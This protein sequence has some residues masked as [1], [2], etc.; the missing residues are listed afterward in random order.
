VKPGDTW[1]R[2]KS[3]HRPAALPISS[4][5]SRRAVSSGGSPA[6][7][8]FAGRKLEHVRHADRLAGLAD[9]EEALA[10]VCDDRD[11]SVAATRSPA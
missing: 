10:V 2:D 3:C 6:T 11:R 8:S 5:S 1:Y 4:A 7:S 9:Q